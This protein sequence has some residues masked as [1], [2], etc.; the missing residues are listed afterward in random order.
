V[1]A[2]AALAATGNFA[3]GRR[4]QLPWGFDS[5]DFN[6]LNV[7]GRTIMQRAIEW[8]ATPPPTLLPI[9]HWKLDDG[10]G[11][12][13]ID[14]EGGHHGTLTNGG[15]VWVAGQLG[16]ALDFDGVDDYVDLTSDAELTDVFDGGATVMAWIYPR[17]W[18]ES[19]NGRILDKSSQV[20]GDR[21]GWMIAVKGDSPS[22]QFAQG[23]TGTRGY[24][25]TQTGS[26]ALN[27]WVHV[28][29]VYDASSVAND[30]EIYL[31]GVKQSSLVEITPT[32]S[33]ATDAGIAL[34]M[35]NWAQDTSRTF[36][37]IIDDVRIYDR[38]LSAAEIADLAV[39]PS[40]VP[41]AHWKLD[42]TSGVNAV[43]SV[44][45]H[46]GTLIDGPVWSAGQIDGALNFDGNKDTIGVPHADTLSL[47]DTMTFIAWVNA[48]SYGANYQ[49]IIA[50]DGGTGS[51][52]N[53]WFGA[54]QND[55][56]FGFFSGGTFR[57]VFT[58]G[59]NLQA[60]TW[61]QLAA[62]F[63]NAKDEVRLYVN[64]AQV[65]SGTLAFSPAAVTADLTIGRSP[66]GEY[67]RGLLDDVRIYD[68]VLPVSEI[69]DLYAVSGGGGG[70]T[71][72]PASVVYEEFTDAA[73]GSNGSS[74]TISKPA[75]TVAGDLLVA[76]VATDGNNTSSLAPPAGW[77]VV[78]VADQGGKV[79]FGVWWKIAGAS[80]STSYTFSWSNSEQAYGWIMRFT[81]F[82][83]SSPVNVTSNDAAASATPLSPSVVTTVA[84]A[85]ILRLGG[86]DEERVT[87]G[88]PGLS[89]HTAINMDSSNG[90]KNSASGGSAYAQQAVAGDSGA[91]SFTLTKSQEYVTVTI[92]ITPAP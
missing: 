59:L 47:T 9:A 1:E 57:E 15:P 44:G 45:G 42:E 29:V 64:G 67:W 39:P 33:I 48:S 43:D 30:A 78:H 70:G 68:S 72:P 58:S 50:K 46:D 40:T 32:G 34:R 7:D 90:G 75:G 31:N 53:Y 19:V 87:V 61:Y 66:I 3:A 71:P 17:S 88:D 5:F 2:G 86:F 23:F 54:W 69:A 56:A 81:G 38:M 83:P 12:T 84:N 4:V 26:V 76:A 35:G 22:F 49:T 13:A 55:L 77:N 92:A 36:D 16:D 80:E 74:L 65:H 51:N 28:A 41:I 24:W 27:E 37:G 91:S 60:G 52:S 63:D 14:S 18:G 6:A 79:T 73:L 85:L 10:T 62:S 20:S 25:R 21:D 82:D 89:G 8:A 11:T